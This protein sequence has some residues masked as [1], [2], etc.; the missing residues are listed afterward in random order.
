MPE[1]TTTPIDYSTK[2]KADLIDL[3]AQRDETIA[4]YRDEAKHRLDVELARAEELEKARAER[5]PAKLLG[6][7]D[8]YDTDAPED[9]LERA[10]QIRAGRIP[11]SLARKFRTNAHL[12]APAGSKLA[13][14]FG[15]K[16]AEPGK[17]ADPMK[18]PLRTEFDVAEMPRESI[19]HFYSVGA[20]SPIG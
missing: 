15:G 5:G 3:L 8:V 17:P 2:S 16:P 14:R 1:P 9:V 4:R 18:I 20:I 13:L 10:Q 19:E 12:R 6:K 11:V 7:I